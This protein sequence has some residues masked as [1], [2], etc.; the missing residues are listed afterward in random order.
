MNGQNPFGDAAA[1]LVGISYE[2]TSRQLPR[3]PKDA[4]LMARVLKRLWAQDKHLVLL[5]DREAT[6]DNVWKRVHGLAGLSEGRLVKVYLAG[7][8]ERDTFFSS[9]DVHFLT[10]DST[11]HNGRIAN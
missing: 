2:G 11:I 6:S 7:H 8:A 1:L 4:R 9:Q 3:A 5:L 10:Q